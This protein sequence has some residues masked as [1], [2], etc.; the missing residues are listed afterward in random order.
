MLFENVSRIA[1]RLERTLILQLRITNCLERQERF[2]LQLSIINSNKLFVVSA[3]QTL[4]A[5][6]LCGW[7]WV[8][9]G[10]TL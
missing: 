8:Y 7:V 5:F 6:V 10:P 4:V 1:D 9:P 2:I 3:V